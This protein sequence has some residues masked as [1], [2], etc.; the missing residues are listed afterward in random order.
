[1][2]KIPCLLKM[3]H[4]AILLRFNVL[5]ILFSIFINS[6][7]GDY[8]L[9]YFQS[10]IQHCFEKAPKSWN[11]YIRMFMYRYFYHNKFQKELCNYQLF[12]IYE[13]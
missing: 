10:K 13:Y 6:G 12:H 1:M 8:T 2:D 9:H 5:F 11:T 4:K 7:N 3:N